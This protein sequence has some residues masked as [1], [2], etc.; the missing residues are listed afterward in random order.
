MQV[1]KTFGYLVDLINIRWRLH[2]MVFFSCTNCGKDVYTF[3]GEHRHHHKQFSSINQILCSHWNFTAYHKWKNN[4]PFGLKKVSNVSHVILIY[5]CLCGS[6]DRT[7]IY[8]RYICH[9]WRIVLLVR[10]SKHERHNIYEK[11]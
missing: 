9:I 5:T 4:W 7:T 10:I 11:H 1:N 3:S 2:L 8:V 6:S